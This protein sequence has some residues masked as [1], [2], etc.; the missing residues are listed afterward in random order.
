[1]VI[2]QEWRTIKSS[3]LL[4][5]IVYPYNDAN[6]ATR[7]SRMNVESW[8]TSVMTHNVCSHV[9]PC[10]E[11]QK[12]AN[13]RGLT[14]IEIWKNEQQIAK[15]TLHGRQSGA[16]WLQEAEWAKTKA[17]QK[18]LTER[19]ETDTRNTKISSFWDGR[20]KSVWIIAWGL[21]RSLWPG[22]WRLIFRRS[23]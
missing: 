8:N 1:M 4:S 2:Y 13:S 9:N 3:R 23:A 10:I 22:L 20:Q 14:Q 17:R 19:K 18:F 21:E 6:A 12:C 16:L 5:D 7:V 11:F 15:A